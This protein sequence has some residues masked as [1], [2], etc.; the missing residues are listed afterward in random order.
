MDN[1]PPV[2]RE[3]HATREGSIEMITMQISAQ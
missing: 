1:L 3:A 2:V